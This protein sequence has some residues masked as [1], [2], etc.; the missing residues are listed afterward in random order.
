MKCMRRGV[1]EQAGRHEPFLDSLPQGRR[2]W[3]R[4]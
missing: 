3:G 1:T 2:E 4:D